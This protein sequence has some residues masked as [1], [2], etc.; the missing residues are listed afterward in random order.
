MSNDR[1]APDV[2]LADEHAGVVDGLGQ[3]QLEDQRL[4]APL[5]EIRRRQGQHVIQLVLLLLQQ[6]V[7]VHAPHQRLALEQPLRVLQRSRW[8]GSHLPI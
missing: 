4:Q 7:L 1:A 6:P 3:A 5:Q 8:Q 2:A